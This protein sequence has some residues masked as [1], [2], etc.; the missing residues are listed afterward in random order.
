[1]RKPRGVPGPHAGG[2]RESVAEAYP[3]GPWVRAGGET[4]GPPRA[5]EASL[6]SHWSS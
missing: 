6:T 5:P 4:K 3:L 2:A 1:M